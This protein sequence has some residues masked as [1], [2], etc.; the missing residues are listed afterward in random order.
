LIVE[1]EWVDR[2]HR[3]IA[4]RS[5]GS[6]V[7]SIDFYCRLERVCGGARELL[8]LGPVKLYEVPLGGGCTAIILETPAGVEAISLRLVQRG[9]APLSP[10]EARDA[11]LEAWRG[12]ECGG[13]ARC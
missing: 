5:G 10:R 1:E 7:Y 9:G 3:V 6:T 11:C 12:S 2:F 13:S 4:L 8:S